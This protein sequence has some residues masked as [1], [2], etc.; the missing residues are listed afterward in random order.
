MMKD[1]VKQLGNCGSEEILKYY[2]HYGDV[3]A[4]KEG[5]KAGLYDGV[6]FRFA[7]KED[8][9]IMTADM[10]GFGCGQ[11]QRVVIDYDA[12]YDCFMIR[13][14]SNMKYGAPVSQCPIIVES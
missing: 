2:G 13:R 1:G 7:R 11:S 8:M 10:A 3:E 9:K 12:G 6:D 4:D 14:Y 5:L